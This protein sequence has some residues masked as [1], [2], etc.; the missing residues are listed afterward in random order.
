[1]PPTEFSAWI[2]S[3]DAA[4]WQAPSTPIVEMTVPAEYQER[5]AMCAFDRRFGPVC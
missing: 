5:Q 4:P 1:V 2:D 3:S